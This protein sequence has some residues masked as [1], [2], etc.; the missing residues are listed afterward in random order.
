MAFLCPTCPHHTQKKPGVK[1][2]DIATNCDYAHT[3][4]KVIHH[5]YHTVHLFYPSSS[6]TPHTQQ[7]SLCNSIAAVS[8]RLLQEN[9]ISSTSVTR[10]KR[11]IKSEHS[12]DHYHAYPTTTKHLREEVKIQFGQIPFRFG[13]CQCEAPYRCRPLPWQQ[14]QQQQQPYQRRA[15]GATS[16]QVFRARVLSFSS[17]KINLTI[18]SKQQHFAQKHG[19][20]VLACISSFLSP[21]DGHLRMRGELNKRPND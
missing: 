11:V 13:I 14:Q 3:C 9:E 16:K 1:V 17:R 21:K 4:T 20:C 19:V 18:P 15:L 2:D 8:S 10:P 5:C 7:P 12:S 6:L